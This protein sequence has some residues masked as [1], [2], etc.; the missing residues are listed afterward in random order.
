M[1]QAKIGERLLR[2]Q[3]EGKEFRE[4]NV[5]VEQPSRG[6]Q[7]RKESIQGSH[8]QPPHSPA[9]QILCGFASVPEP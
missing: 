2:V 7:R 4:N 5:Y 6:G 8:M 3:K 1:C 9:S